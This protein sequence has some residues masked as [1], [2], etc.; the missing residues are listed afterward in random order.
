MDSPCASNGLAVDKPW[1]IVV[2][3]GLALD[4]PQFAPWFVHGQLMD[5]PWPIRGLPARSPWIGHGQ[6]I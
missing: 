4:S 3:H 1:T 5:S 6:S 2:V